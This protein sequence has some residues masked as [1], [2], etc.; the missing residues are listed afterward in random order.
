M[1]KPEPKSVEPECQSCKDHWDNRKPREPR[2]R[3]VMIGATQNKKVA[4]LV[5]P[6]CDGERAI[7]LAK[8]KP[9]K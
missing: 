2:K 6:Y 9:K 4:V 1:G 8:A 7:A 5:C 3:L